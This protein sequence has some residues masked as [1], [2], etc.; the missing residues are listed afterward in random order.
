MKA[1]LLTDFKNDLDL[2]HISDPDCPC[3]GV[4][5]ELR[6]CGV[7]RSDHHAW[8]GIDVGI[9]LPHLLGHEFS[10][11]I[12]EVGKNC[13]QFKLGDR[14]TAP[15]ILGCGNCPDCRSGEST[16][17]NQQKVI[18]FSQAGAFAQY[19]AIHHAD[20]NLVHLPESLEFTAA[21]AM[22]CR[23]TSAFRGIVDRA[24]IQ[25]GEWLVVHGCGGVGLSAVMIAAALGAQVCAVDIENS[26]LQLANDF[27][28]NK[29]INAKN[30]NLIESIH[31]A[32]NGGAHV[33]LDALGTTTTFEN[34]LHSLRKLG[35]HVQLG[36]PL[37]QHA[38]PKLALLELIYYRQLSLYGSRGMGAARFPVLMSMIQG[39]RLNP[40]ALVKNTIALD[41]ISTVL[42]QMDH[43]NQ[44]GVSVVTDFA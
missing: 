19:V 13:N 4:I 43:F 11:V 23:V 27:G 28:A 38:T 15:F 2:T 8:S 32:T 24:Q 12:T 7:C 17:C 39:G 40:A 25:P 26:A 33:S 21:A 9:S 6:A 16:L 1:A 14:V 18:G 20:Y 37:G 30:D 42:K 35:R 3:D 10:G 31:E 5:I 41:Q 36:K 44:A 22:G 34:S 29:C